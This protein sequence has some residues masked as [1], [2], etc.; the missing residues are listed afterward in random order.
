MLEID[1]LVETKTYIDK[2]WVVARPVRDFRF[3]IR[4]K[5]AF[6]VFVGRAEAISFYKQ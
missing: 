4:L 1:S 3:H 2:K 6:F 5:D